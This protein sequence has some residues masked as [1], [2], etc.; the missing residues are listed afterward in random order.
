MHS[1]Y[2]DLTVPKKRRDEEL[3][4]SMLDTLHEYKEVVKE[5]DMWSTLPEDSLNP[6]ERDLKLRQQGE[7]ALVSATEEIL[8]KLRDTKQTA[9]QDGLKINGEMKQMEKTLKNSMSVVSSTTASYASYKVP[10]KDARE[11]PFASFISTGQG[12]LYK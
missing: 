5:S 12:S 2:E 4:D 8:L 7:K 3:L 6:A 9:Y 10:G 11:D 1:E